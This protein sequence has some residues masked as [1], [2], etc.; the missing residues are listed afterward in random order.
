MKFCRICKASDH[1]IDQCPSKV[2][3]GSCPSK[4]IIPLQVIQ[5][6]ELGEQ[7]QK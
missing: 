3:S 7:E 4:E 6:K 5:I 2:V 1:I